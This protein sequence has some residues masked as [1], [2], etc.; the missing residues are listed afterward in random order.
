MKQI[1]HFNIYVDNLALITST[2]LS[3][4]FTEKLLSPKRVERSYMLK[5]DYI[6]PTLPRDL[7]WNP[8]L[9]NEGNVLL[10]DGAICNWTLGERL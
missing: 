1:Y 6:F 10:A 2:E 9:P 4:V 8:H 5:S 3:I 7:I